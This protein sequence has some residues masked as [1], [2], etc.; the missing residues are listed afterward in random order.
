ML[1]AKSQRRWFSPTPACLIYGLLIVEGL[2]WLSERYTWFGFNEKKGWTVLIAVAVVGVAML[3]M[4]GWFI[5]SLLF[6]WRF[7]FSIRSLLVLTVA[8]AVPCSW[9]AV[10]MKAAKRQREVAEDIDNS[11]GTAEYGIY[12]MPNPT[13]PAPWLLNLLGVD[14]FSDVTYVTLCPQDADAQLAHLKDLPGIW[15]LD[16]HGTQVTDAWLEYIE[17]LAELHFLE[18]ENTRVTDAGLEHL[19]GLTQ[20]QLLCIRD[21]QITGAGLEHL[22]ALLQLHELEITDTQV[23]DAGLEHLDGLSQLQDLAINS[24]RVT[25]AGL[26]HLKGLTRLKSL[27]IFGCTLVTQAGANRLQQAL[28]NCQVVY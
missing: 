10:E 7:Q 27:R 5:V 12:Y 17:G 9:L 14:F 11:G 24:T 28:P 21:T 23:T 20:L 25:D 3:L 19:R 13:L 22:K 4:L 1:S 8:V 18:L 26:E 16:L 15:G 6:R 2:L